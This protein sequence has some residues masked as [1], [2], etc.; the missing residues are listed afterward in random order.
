MTWTALPGHRDRHT[1]VPGW[2]TAG[3][4]RFLPAPHQ[5][6]SFSFQFHLTTLIQGSQGR[7]G[8]AEGWKQYLQALQRIKKPGPPS[9]HPSAPNTREKNYIDSSQEEISPFVLPKWMRLFTVVNT[10]SAA[11]R[12]GSFSSVAKGRSVSS[13][14]IP[15]SITANSSITRRQVGPL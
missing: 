11:F 10:R 8:E 6:C 9:T 14:C 3:S 13:L 1:F 7:N 2:R 5:H 15:V 12:E 4:A